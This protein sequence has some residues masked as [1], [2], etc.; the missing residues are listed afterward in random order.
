MKYAKRIIACS[1]I[2]LFI[3]SNP[4]FC[5]D[6]K[7]EAGQYISKLNPILIDVQMLARNIGQKFWSPATAAK[8]MRGYIDNL[9]SLA[10]PEY[11][12]KQHKM[13]LLSF[14][15]LMAGFNELSKGNRPIAVELV[16]K[17]GRLLKTAVNDI[18]DFAKK[19]GIIKEKGKDQ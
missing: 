14:E 1:L 8:Q 11:L 2:S 7:E 13:I 18:V 3:L 15:K 19:E 16:R 6:K 10:P 9:R 17:G 12:A 5:I 4:G